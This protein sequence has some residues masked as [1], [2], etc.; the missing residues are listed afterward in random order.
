M[1]NNRV[2]NIDPCSTYSVRLE[3]LSSNR[4]LAMAT[5]F[6]IIHKMT[7]FLITNWHVLSG[8]NP[9]TNQVL[10]QNGSV[11]DT[12]RVHHHHS[13]RLGIWIAKTYSLYDNKGNAKWI[14]HSE[15]KSIDVAVL[16]LVPMDKDVIVYSFD[17]SMADEDAIPVPGM[18]VFI[19]G[20]PFGMSTAGVLPIWKTGHIAS[21]PDINYEGK[22]IF[23]I[24]ATTRGGMSGA[25][26]I[27]R[28]MGGYK[29]KSGKLILSGGVTKFLGI[30]SGRIHEYAEIGKVWKPH[31]INDIL[32][33][34]DSNEQSV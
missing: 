3:L 11:P 28:L 32:N 14:E 29:T 30:Y 10:S 22:P 19:I 4:Q 12:I 31:L 18:P 23:L 33:T 9:E 8:I 5:G 2:I 20:F 6:I 16:P 21:D 25:P 27:L 15:G 24:D 34:Y 7:P 26:V 13:S 17:L 1:P